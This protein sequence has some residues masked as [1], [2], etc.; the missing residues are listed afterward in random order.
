MAGFRIEGNTSAN[1][2][3]VDSANRILTTT[4]GGTVALVNSGGTPIRTIA[5]GRLDIGQD[6]LLFYDSFDDTQVDSRK[7]LQYVTTQT[8]AISTGQ[9]LLNSGAVTTINTN[10]G[11]LSHAR[12]SYY[13]EAA[14]YA[15]AGVMPV[16]LP[17]TNS[18]AEWGFGIIASATD[19]SAPTDGAFFRWKPDGLFECVLSFGGTE[20]K[21][22][23]T[24][25]SQNVTHHME[26]ELNEEECVFEIDGVEVAVILAPTGTPPTASASL[27][28]FSRVYTGAS[29]P[30]LAPQ[31]KIAG[32]ACTQQ[33]LS[34]YKP[35]GHTMAIAGQGG[36]W[37]PVTPYAGTNGSTNALVLPAAA[38]QSNTVAPIT[39]L[40]G[41]THITAPAGAD[42]AAPID[43]ILFAYQVPTGRRFVC[44]GFLLSMMNAGAA[45]A[46]TPTTCEFSIGVGATAASLATADSFTASPQPTF[47]PRK[48]YLGML[49]LPIGAAI[50]ALAGEIE[51]SFDTPLVC[52]GGK[53][54]TGIM[55]VV[56]GTATA[57]QTLRIMTQPLGYFE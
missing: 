28:L 51:R 2:A 16:N 10:S 56:V 53:F 15:H 18:T 12:Y 1:V 47:A 36:A 4:S 33:L 27:P 21:V 11:V 19:R 22:T 38:A 7:W 32:W 50:G 35:W 49:S 55:R 13:H 34:T 24:A 29:A 44:T 48:R 6:S 43:A 45:V 57:S 26:V 17:A 54:I 52:E 40:G 46:T 25:P 37:S 8:V 39:T 42:L 31:L 3:E 20:Q 5:E 14:I 30:S 41:R 23:V 9:M